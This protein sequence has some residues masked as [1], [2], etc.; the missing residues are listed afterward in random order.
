MILTGGSKL[1]SRIQ[2]SVNYFSSSGIVFDDRTNVGLS[3]GFGRIGQYGK[4][5]AKV[6]QCRAKL[7]VKESGEKGTRQ[8]SAKQEQRRLALE[9]YRTRFSEALEAELAEEMQAMKERLRNWTKQRLQDEGM[10]IFDLSVKPDGKLYRDTILRFYR[11]QG[12]GILPVHHQFSQGDVI[13]IS[14]KNPLE[15]EGSVIEGVVMER[16]RRFLRVAVSASQS[17]NIDMQLK[18]R[19]DLSANRVAF[20]RCMWAINA[21][22]SPSIRQGI[23]QAGQVAT[24][25]KSPS[26]SSTPGVI[27]DTEPIIGEGLLSF[28][29]SVIGLEFAK[30]KDE[31][32]AVNISLSA[33]AS[34]LMSNP[35]SRMTQVGEQKGVI[36]ALLKE[37]DLN[38]SQKTAIQKAMLRRLTLWQGP[39]GTGKTR[40][41]VHYLRSYCKQGRRQ[42]LACA[43]SNVAVDNLV[44]GLL[45]QGLRVVRVGQ[46]VKVKE[47][48]RESTIAAQ[49]AAHPLMKK[50][51]LLREEAI[52]RR[53]ESRQINNEKL[54]KAGATQATYVWEKAGDL[55]KQVVKAILDRADV[56]CSTCVGAGDMVLD[57]RKFE[58]C[59][60]DEA[61]QATEPA[62]LIPVLRSGAETIVLV[63]DPAQLPPTVIS[64]D[65]IEAGLT[66]TL[67]ERLQDCGVQPF[68]LD[69]QYRMHPVLAAWPSATFYNNRLKS[70]VQPSERLIPKGLQW[71]NKEKPLVFIECAGLE[72]TTA[73]GNSWFNRAEALQVVKVVNSLIGS[74]VPDLSSVDI[75]VITPY[76]AQVRLLQ[77]LL[78][79]SEDADKSRFTDLEVKTVDG[80]QGREKEVIVISTVRANAEGR[81]GF[82]ADPRRMNVAL[83]RAKRG[84]VV[85]GHSA[86]LQ[87]SVHWKK[88][89]E[90]A[91]KQQL[92]VE[93]KVQSEL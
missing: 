53:K 5:S 39:P 88:W 22:A 57:G 8:R 40:T 67:F 35:P 6:L 42:V 91:R 71:P 18:W 34:S 83:T 30:M 86:T 75:G 66:R 92:I 13:A 79:R 59:V 11:A 25:K 10:A 85:I 17:G 4:K 64:N 56:V 78:L 37:M 7:R 48:L 3:L 73:L 21:F 55:E 24:T 84:L 23:A 89:I 51:E 87:S 68:L 2:R 58:A 19:L 20:E 61:S 26:K 69:T 80:F 90:M 14:R 72:E 45:Q 33:E 54:R 65:A 31:A 38:D 32:T 52:N 74:K 29:D 46:P 93:S 62:T 76:S 82:V 28:R 15:E 60:I 50:V 36:G 27:A 47:E 70:N 49:V 77:D 12:D 81:L 44:E 9:S 41:L 43:D 63:G 1:Q 16:A